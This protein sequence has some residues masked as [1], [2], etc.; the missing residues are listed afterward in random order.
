MCNSCSR[1][2]FTLLV[3]EIKS[4]E[5][6]K[7]FQLC[8]KDRPW[9]SCAIFCKRK[10][11]DVFY[12]PRLDLNNLPD[13]NPF[14]PDGTWCGNDGSK[15]YYCMQ[16]NCIAKVTISAMT[17][18]D[19]TGIDCT[20]ETG[21]TSWESH[22]RWHHQQLRHRDTEQRAPLGWWATTAASSIAGIFHDG[23]E[24]Q[25]S[26]RG[27]RSGLAERHGEQLC[28]GWL[29]RCWFHYFEALIGSPWTASYLNL[30]ISQKWLKLK[31]L[32]LCG[33]RFKWKPIQYN[34]LV[35]SW[36]F[37]RNWCIHLRL[38]TDLT[39]DN[40]SNDVIQGQSRLDGHFG[41]N[42]DEFRFISKYLLLIFCLLFVNKF[43]Y[44]CACRISVATSW[45]YLAHAIR[46]LLSNLVTSSVYYYF[47]I[48]TFQVDRID[49]KPQKKSSEV[50]QISEGGGGGRGLRRRSYC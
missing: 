42:S 32:L 10:D 22:G 35:V 6:F 33:G 47:V 34:S 30:F 31:W 48:V 7:T 27:S 20:V 28:P 43:D 9:Q 40:K 18:I 2:D 4:N 1:L 24:W 13:L 23:L 41:L 3:I 36:R 11:L 26:Q 25:S 12:T 49:R 39:Y 15:D 46:Q 50:T 19:S 44:W 45:N 17:C 29:R 5:K 37:V 8:L 38:N 14:Y 16:R 21:R